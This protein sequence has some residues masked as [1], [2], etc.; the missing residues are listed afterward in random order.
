M[1][2]M[3]V[4]AADL[5]QKRCF[6]HARREAAAVCL[7]CGRYFCRECI[8]EHEGKVVCANCLSADASPDIKKQRFLMIRH[9]FLFLLS[10]FFLWFLFFYLGRFLFSLPDAFHEGTFWKSIWQN[11]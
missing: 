8:T 10:L 9:A 4:D 2:P 3:P 11:I 5:S 7:S 6:H 1:N